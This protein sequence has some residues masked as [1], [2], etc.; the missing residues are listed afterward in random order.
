MCIK[1]KVKQLF[2]IMFRVINKC[3][4]AFW[5]M[6]NIIDKKI[7]CPLK[8]VL[9]TKHLI[10]DVRELFLQEN[11][12]YFNRYD[13]IVRYLA[14]E[15]FYN[16]NTCG[17]L[18]YKKMQAMRISESW[19]EKSVERFVNLI[20]SYHSNGYDISSEIEL[21]RNLKLIDGS[22]RISL[23]LFHKQYRIYCKIRPISINVSYGLGWFV[24]NGFS[25][26][27]IE[28][29]QNTYKE[30]CQTISVPFTV[31]LWPPVQK[32]FDD[33]LDRLRLFGDVIMYKDYIYDDSSF[34]SMVRGVYSV[35][36]MAKWKVEKKI[37]Y[38]SP[39]SVKKVRVVILE[40]DHPKF[41]LKSTNNSALSISCERIKKIIRAC[42]K[43][44]IE[45]YIYD[46]IIHIGDNYY[47]NKHIRNIF[48]T[49]KEG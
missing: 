47:Q 33:I 7:M 20:K 29:I 35:S 42:Y 16:K 32:Y 22:H 12:C 37:A 40:L 3:N 21:D 44:R 34:G 46:I 14:I 49:S 17:F 19:V 28:I 25:M 9:W 27:E 43:D 6:L 26:E 39:V 24:E 4:A 10:W 45:G 2:Y 11:E 18:L 15:N 13:I 36:D 38:M 48:E 30:I 1:N 41:C 31:T 23:A 5:N 8:N